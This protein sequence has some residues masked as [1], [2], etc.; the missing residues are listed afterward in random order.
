[1]RF[2]SL[3]GSTNNWVRKQRNIKIEAQGKVKEK[4]T[5]KEKREGGEGKQRCDERKEE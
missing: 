5:V 4:I 2:D 1:M 3:K